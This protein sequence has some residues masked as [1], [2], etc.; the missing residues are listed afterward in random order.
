[1]VDYEQEIRNISLKVMEKYEDVLQDFEKKVAEYVGMGTT[2]PKAKMIALKQIKGAFQAAMRSKAVPFEGFVFAVS[3]KRNKN[4]VVYK[5]AMDLINEY[6]TKYA[7]AWLTR[8]VADMICDA[9]GSPIFGAHNTSEAQKWMRKQVI[10]EF[11][12]EKVA[13]GFFRPIHN[14]ESGNPITVPLKYGEIRVSSPDKHLVM[15]GSAYKFRCGVSDEQAPELK[16]RVAAITKFEKTG[17]IDFDVAKT[18]MESKFTLA[19]FIDVYKQ[20]PETGRVV[21]PEGV[22][23]RMTEVTVVST[24]ITEGFEIDYVEFQSLHEDDVDENVS[25]IIPKISNTTFDNAVGIVIYRPYYSKAKPEKNIESAPTGE[26]IG[27]LHDSSLGD[28]PPTE[29]R[30]LAE[31]DF[32]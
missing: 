13:Y 27:F 28:A 15:P 23:I 26:V 2:E 21:M 10:K 3:Q 8:A 30:A 9:Q 24:R 19:P 1:M 32:E 14:D 16:M 31:G 11:D 6:K 29:M 22:Y 25:M 7:S 12:W 20:D 4:S 17:P 5:D 18:F